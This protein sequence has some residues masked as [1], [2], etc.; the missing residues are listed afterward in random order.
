MA[1]CPDEAGFSA[2]VDATCEQSRNIA[3]VDTRRR[4]PKLD[5][6][7][8]DRLVAAFSGDPQFQYARKWFRPDTLRAVIDL[9]FRIAK[10]ADARTQRLLFVAAAQEIRTV[11]SVDPRCTHHLVTKK[12]DFIDPRALVAARALASLQTLT[13]A[14]SVR[15]DAEIHQGSILAAQDANGPFDFVLAH[16]P[17]LGVIHYHLIHRLATDLLHFVNVTESPSTL[18]SYDF[19]SET[20]RG[21]DVSTDRSEKYDQFVDDLGRA[22]VPRLAPDGVCAV[23]IGDQRHK[24]H[25]RHPFTRVI[26]VMES[27]GLQLAEN[28]IWLLQNNGGMHVL[29]RGHFIDHN[30]ILVFKRR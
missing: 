21:V 12:R 8:L 18:R 13:T 2:A 23:I 15:R 20:I 4:A 3:R 19:S 28:F 26:Q 9:L 27:S 7:D 30:Y 14:H 24:G 22:I 5:P 10:V 1:G 6:P 16:P 25:L 17:Y 11:A 29:R